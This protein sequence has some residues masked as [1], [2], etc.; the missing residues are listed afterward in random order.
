MKEITKAM[1]NELWFAKLDYND[2]LAV[3]NEEEE[4]S[5]EEL[6]EHVQYLHIEYLAKKED[7]LGQYLA[8]LSMS[9]M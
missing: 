7:I 1:K 2:L 4:I 5:P 8:R 9:Y 6:R 3:A